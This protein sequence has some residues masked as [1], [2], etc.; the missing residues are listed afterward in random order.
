MAQ[1]ILSAAAAAG[2]AGIG[3]ILARTVAS[4]AASYVAGA[5]ER[6][7]FG[8]RKRTVE[9]PR[10][11]S[12]TIQSSTEGAGVTRVWG[13]ARVA[14]QLIW[15]ANFKETVAETTESSGGKGGRLAASKTTFREYVYSLSFAVGLCEGE[16]D[17]VA[18]V[19]AD[20][21]PFD[22]SKVNHR[23]YRGTPT[24][25]PDALI[26]AV[27]GG[28]PAFRG[29]AY[30]VFEDLP[31][32]DFGNRI[33]Q[34]SFE[35]EKALG[36]D[37]PVALENALAAV[38]LIPGSGE[39]IYGTT[40]VTREAG[41]GVTASEN[42]NNNDGVTDFSASLTALTGAAKNLKAASLVV[43]WFG[44][45]L[46]AGVCRLT[47]GVE[48]YDKTTTPADWRGGGVARGQARLVSQLDG[49]PAYGGTSDDTGVI[50]AIQALKAKG[51][52]VM[53]HP[54]ILMDIPPT[55]NLPSPEGAGAQP[56]YPWR[57]RI[58]V[59]A[60]EGS[61]GAAADILAFFGSAAP[62]DF[63]LANGAVA[64]AGPAEWSFRR[65]ILH[66]A[67]LCAAAGGV[68]AFLIGSEL[69]ALT[70]ARDHQ[71]NFPAVAALISLAAEV[72]AILPAA[73]ISYGADWS[74]WS[75]VTK[76]D[77]KYFHLDEFW[78]DPN[79]AFIGIDYYPPLAD[80]RDGVDHADLNAGWNG[81]HER[82]YIAA[83]IEGG[84]N[85]SWY[86]AS[87]ADRDAQA[88]TPINDAAYNEA[89]VWRA[90]DIR[91]WWKNTHHHRPN[92]IRDAAPTPWVPKS[93]PVR[94]TEFGCPA[95]DKGANAPNV[96]VDPKS[97]ESALP[98]FSS[99]ARDELAQRRTLEAVH[100]YWRAHNES[101][102]GV[103]MIETDRLYV[104]AFDARPFPYFP[105]RADIWGDA[106][107]WEKGHWLN[108]R[109]TR[110][111][112]DALVAALCA[113]ADIQ[114]V[115][116][117]GLKGSI[118]GYVVDRPLSPRQMID[119]L[120]DV[121]QFDM[122]ETATGLRF[123][124]RGGASV[125]SLDASMLADDAAGRE[126]RG[127]YAVTIGHKADLPTAVR[128]GY[129]DE[130]GDYLPALAEARLPFADDIREIGMELPAVMDEAAAAARARSILADAGVMRETASFALPPS[131]AAL[132]PGDAVRL[133]LGA[134][135]RDYRIV[136]MTDGAT[137][138]VEAVRV[139]RAVY[140][141]APATGGFKAP[142]IAPQFGPPAF[143]LMN[144]PLLRDDDDP[145]AP[146]F[147]VHAE[148]W[149]GAIALYRGDALA[150]TAT[151]RA[152]IGRL[153]APLS[154]GASGRWDERSMR[155]RLSFG[156]LVS[157]SAEEVLAGANAAAV[158]TPA[159]WEILQFRDASLGPDGAWTLTGLLRG[160]SGSEQEA[161]AGAPANARFVLL[162][163]AIVQASLPF[164]LRGLAF[165]WAAG[166]ADDHP[167]APTFR[168]R[169]FTGEARGARP[170]SPVHLM[171]VETADGAID[172]TW[173]R[174]TRKGGD[175]WAGEDVPLSETYERYR[176]E[177]YAGAALIRTAEVSAP[178][179]TYTPAMLAADFPGGRPALTIRVAQLSDLVGAGAWGEV[180]A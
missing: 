125:A 132:E 16:I 70:T 144:L 56:A 105:A 47:P 141:D 149:P 91:N 153:D 83:N 127:A 85:F 116:A 77:G 177:I 74:E 9:G 95:V 171:A 146:Y 104:Y 24:Q 61:A 101:A 170:L 108:G 78:A 30:I 88:R 172:V 111:P 154:P 26:D 152:V 41:E 107:N 66:Y 52:A 98:P 180:G 18:R 21:K 51:L 28:A 143:E 73:K 165:D 67:H 118:A 53:F 120:A 155:V 1:L 44:D 5:A 174:R 96:F 109:L 14:G 31:L 15:A 163:G 13:R 151:A 162:T 19:W 76:A 139:A 138:K 39:F 33:P 2:R 90:K 36:E 112:L 32:K 65:M 62:G 126:A 115:D 131:F 145:A 133:D 89:W 123:Q 57:G 114:G 49:R 117:S 69:R 102:G 164:D 46:R 134:T 40:K 71:G 45:D 103:S 113:Q 81:Q 136:S 135:A 59:G 79:V 35:I 60:H 64:Y 119:P 4:T 129:I 54:F 80:W 110:A 148:P 122:T 82:A 42:V 128:L 158:E 20:G 55:N 92:F 100:E 43:A 72:K 97:S 7:I 6:L 93:K 3:T 167:T 169:N 23:V 58:G 34:L 27:E 25:T 99:G 147:A 159:G 75:G 176:V 17:R 168:T 38:T 50:E 86:Y 179:F 161:A 137:R 29:L 94:F 160:Q 84:E 48:T 166:P 130:G 175:S 37:D 157:K 10:L 173:K 11:D 63:S 12:F 156:A 140:E 22:L 150:A 106:A 8:P 87:P 124:P 68:E 178:A 121:F 142:A